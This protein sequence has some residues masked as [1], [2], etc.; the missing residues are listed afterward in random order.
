MLTRRLGWAGLILP[1]KAS[2]WG[3]STVWQPGCWQALEGRQGV[4]WSKPACL[5]SFEDPVGAGVL[6]SVLQGL[7]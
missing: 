2:L 7:P 1:P 6:S 5:G 4:G 3:L